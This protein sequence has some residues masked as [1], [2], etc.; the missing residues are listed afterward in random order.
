MIK[1]RDFKADDMMAVLRDGICECNLQHMG[2][3]RLRELA[4]K[5]EKEGVSYTGEVDG[6]VVGCAG[7]D[8]YWK[9]V[10]EIWSLISSHLRSNPKQTY[11]CIKEGL[12]IIVE[13]YAVRTLLA[14]ARADF[15]EAQRMLEHL[16]FTQKCRIENYN[17]DHTD[18]YLYVR[19]S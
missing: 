9:G 5:R 8:I 3:D 1:V 2:N 6:K 10:G 18:A 4:E 19:N 12:R 14:Y 11:R 17:P 13:C 15:P 16:G 7:V